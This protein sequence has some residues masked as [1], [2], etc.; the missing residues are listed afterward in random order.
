MRLIRAGFVVVSLVG[1]AGCVDAEGD[2]A[3]GGEASVGATET[4]AT[5]SD[6]DPD[7][8]A[9]SDPSSASS[10]ATITASTTDSTSTTADE[11]SDTTGVSTASTDV[12]ATTDGST[13]EG[14]AD[15]GEGPETGGDGVVYSA[16]AII[17]ALD[18]VEI[19]KADYDNDLCMWVRIVWP[20][21]VGSYPGVTT[22][23]DWTVEQISINDVA[24]ACEQD[25]PGMFGAEAATGA[26]GAITFGRLGQFN[27]PCTIDVDVDAQFAGNLPDIPAQVSMTATE[28]PVDGAC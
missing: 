15:R 19:R 26:S 28:V 13:S 22:P 17:G 14:S 18:R 27:Y 2:E 20:S 5:A 9:S 25:N 8:S 11:T 3:D 16:R 7:P 12:T 21:Q 23:T 10:S 4:A 6:D 24:T 1:P